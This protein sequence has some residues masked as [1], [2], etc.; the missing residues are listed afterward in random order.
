MRPTA[1]SLIILLTTLIL[2]GLHTP[3]RAALQGYYES[4]RDTP[5]FAFE[6]TDPVALKYAV[7]NLTRSIHL[8][9]NYLPTD[10][11]KYTLKG[12]YPIR[13]LS[14][15]SSTEGSRLTFLTSPSLVT[16]ITYHINLRK[17]IT[18]YTRDI[19]NIIHI[20][21]T[22]DKNQTAFLNGYTDVNFYASQLNLALQNVERRRLE[23]KNRFRCL[24]GLRKVCTTKV[25][26]I[27]IEYERQEN[28]TNTPKNILVRNKDILTEA[29]IRE[30]ARPA[31]SKTTESI[32]DLPAVQLGN[33]ACRYFTAPPVMMFWWSTSRISNS[34]IIRITPVNDL[35]F[36]DLR[37]IEGAYYETLREAGIGYQYQPLN[38]YLCPDFGHDIGLTLSSYYI[39]NEI[40][41]HPIFDIV[42]DEDVVFTKLKNLEQ[43]IRLSHPIL[44]SYKITA[45]MKDVQLLLETYEEHALI[46]N[47]GKEKLSRLYSFNTLWKS[48]GAWI[49]YIIGNI[50]D[51]TLATINV[52]RHQ[53]IP[54]TALFLTRSYISTLFFLSNETIVEAPILLTQK[55]ENVSLEK[56]YLRSYNNDLIHKI[57]PQELPKFINDSGLRVNL[58]MTPELFNDRF[59]R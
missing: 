8:S 27:E 39:Q 12:L 51:M 33:G 55:R 15:I 7:E 45:F 22:F 34:D 3:S 43:K 44:Q 48:K 25:T 11:Q 16:A 17:T 4:H 9:A 56:F 10:S 31:I 29:M 14:T 32:D 50:D 2:F 5:L 42:S 20:L 37:T 23:E 46:Q 47:L 35:L 28:G 24:F 18:A 38:P 30:Y 49:E 53:E 21:N 26:D 13:F 57:P 58:I 6:G 54:L 41:T 52:S 1:T 59:K 19:K 36:Y 40:I